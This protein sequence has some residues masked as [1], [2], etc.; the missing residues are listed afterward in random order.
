VLVPV[1]VPV[2]ILVDPDL[3]GSVVVLLDLGLVTAAGHATVELADAVTDLA[4]RLARGRGSLAGL[5][6][7]VVQVARALAGLESD[8]SLTGIAGVAIARLGRASPDRGH[9]LARVR[10]ATVASTGGLAEVPRSSLA[11][12]G[13]RDVDTAEVANVDLLQKRFHGHPGLG[14]DVTRARCGLV[15][16]VG[17]GVRLVDAGGPRRGGRCPETCDHRANH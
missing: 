7:A 11:G 5:G 3:A 10:V 13:R 15:A 9:A 16:R 17:F 1:L 6:H 2:A 12:I 8:R 14:F 4:D